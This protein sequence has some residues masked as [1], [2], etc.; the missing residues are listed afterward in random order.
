[1]SE[2]IA[3]QRSELISFDAATLVNSQRE[4]FNTRETFNVDFRI[5][6]LKKLKRIIIDNEEALL[7]AL[8]KDLHKSDFEGYG[9]EVGFV[10]GEIDF[11]LKHLKSWVKPKRV[12]TPMFHAIGSSYIYSDPY[13]VV[14]VI[15]PW[16]Y[17]FQLTIAPVVGAIAAGNCC[18]IK[19]SEISEHTGILMEKLLNENFDEKY[20]KVVLGG[21]AESKAL[22]EQRFDYIFFTGGTEIGRYIY[23]AAAK[24]LTPVTLELGGKSPCI[25]DEDIHLDYAAKRIIWG[26]FTNAGQTCVAPDYLLVHEKVKD[27]LVTKMKEKY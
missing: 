6:Q 23:Q 27:K 17:P 4:Y 20:I 7:E 10:L 21:V 22:L 11:T 8:H 1:M 18:I 2:V 25:V 19:P 15:A 14:F 24:H 26:K 13:G 3:P 12:S 16:N 9:T 5:A